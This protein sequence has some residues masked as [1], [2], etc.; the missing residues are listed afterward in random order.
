MEAQVSDLVG[1]LPGKILWKAGEPTVVWRRLDPGEIREPYFDE[2]LK[3]SLNDA[4]IEGKCFHTPI[5]MLRE[6]AE[7]PATEAVAVPAPT[8][9]LFH[10]SR[11]GARMVAQMLAADYS[12]LVLNEFQPIDALL[13]CQLWDARATP[14]WRQEQLRWLLLATARAMPHRTRL[15][16]RFENWQVLQLPVVQAAFPLVP[17]AFLYREPLEVLASHEHRCGSLFVPGELEPELFGWELRDIMRRPFAVH[18][19]KVL[20]AYGQ[21]ALTGLAQGHG[22]LLNHSELP[23]AAYEGLL[24]AFNVPRDPDLLAVM[25]KTARYH[26]RDPKTLSPDAS[27]QKLRDELPD[28]AAAVEAYAAEVY[29]QL[30]AARN[31]EFGLPEH[32]GL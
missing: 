30:E 31:G 8:G 16:V 2:T 18:W 3:A 27:L 29:H 21:A 23:E 15:F 12:H 1:W 5:G 13:R 11:S 26:Q 17:W 22:Y 32:T 24:K 25:A 9:F 7:A 20:A 28:H 10:W 19:A 6:V 14:E 4:E